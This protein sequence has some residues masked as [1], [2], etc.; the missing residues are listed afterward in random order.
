MQNASKDRFYPELLKE[1]DVI[2]T[3]GLTYENLTNI[4][5]HCKEDGTPVS[6]MKVVLMPRY[7]LS[8]SHLVQVYRLF[9]LLRLGTSQ[10]HLAGILGR[11]QSVISM[12]LSDTLPVVARVLAKRFLRTSLDEALKDRPEIIAELFPAAKLFVDGVFLFFFP[13]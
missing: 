12:L 3:C 11:Q 7:I 10:R 5:K 1:E 4:V 2:A 6:L 13:F 9:L 8:Y